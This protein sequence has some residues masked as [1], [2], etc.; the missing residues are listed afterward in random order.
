MFPVIFIS[1]LT[2]KHPNKDIP[3]SNDSFTKMQMIVSYVLSPIFC[4]YL[5]FA[6]YLCFLG[7]FAYVI[8][9]K[10]CVRITYLE[11]LLMI[12]LLGIQAERIRKFIAL[13]NKTR[14]ERTRL[15]MKDKWNIIYFISLITFG[16][17]LLLRITSTI[18]YK[19]LFFNNIKARV[20]TYKFKN[21]NFMVE[22]PL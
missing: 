15:L 5:D 8:L 13:G 3:S 6:S 2:W 14:S 10:F 1:G 17:G 11:Y 18:S 7:L 12:W 4:F 21:N 16:A 9:V 22:H 19:E 20:L